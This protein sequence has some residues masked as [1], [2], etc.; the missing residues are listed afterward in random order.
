MN[1][2]EGY[3][4]LV[5]FVGFYIQKPVERCPWFLQA[6][7]IK[8]TSLKLLRFLCTETNLSDATTWFSFM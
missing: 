7:V 2:L 3:Y 6:F 8:E 4:S 5:N 1:L